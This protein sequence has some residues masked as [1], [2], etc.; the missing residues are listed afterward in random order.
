MIFI[1]HT[2]S[3]RGDPNHH[4]THAKDDNTLII[5]L[6]TLAV[7]VAVIVV[8]R[9]LSKPSQPENPKTPKGNDK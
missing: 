6:L 2:A 1:A 5:A 9:T 3:E 4:L 8:I 7:I